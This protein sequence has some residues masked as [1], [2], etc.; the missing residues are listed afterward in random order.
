[1]MGEL[2]SKE[3]RP[4]LLERQSRGGDINEG[5]ISFQLEVV[6]SMIPR[7][8]SVEGF[9]GII[10]EGMADTEA[11][12]FV[13]ARGYKKEFIEVKDHPVTPIEFWNEIE[14]FQQMDA[15]S[16]GEYE[17][18]TVKSAGLSQDLHPLANGLR[19]LRDPYDFYEGS[20]IMDNSYSEYARIVTRLG[21]PKE[22]GDFLYRKVLIY[23]DL[24]TVRDHGFGV[25]QQS[26]QNYLPPYREMSGSVLHTVHGDVSSLVQSKRN[27]PI[28]RKEL[29]A[30]LRK[31]VP[32]PLL[33]PHQ[34]VRIHTAINR[35]ATDSDRTALRFE[36]ERFFAHESRKYPP[37]DV[38]N[39]ELLGELRATKDWILA[40]R[41]TRRIALSGNRRLSA[42][43]AIGSVFSAVAGFSIEMQYRE[44]IYATDTHAGPDTPAY[45]LITRAPEEPFV[46]DHL[47]VSIGILRDI[48]PE[49]DSY[50][51]SCGMADMPHLHLGGD[52][53]IESA[54]QANL[55]VRQIKDLISDTLVKTGSRQID[56]FIAAPAFLAL[57]LGH[58][59]N[60]TA[61]VRCYEWTN[62]SGYVPTC[63][64]F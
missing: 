32:E 16:P 2:E 56:L 54:E 55:I 14:R 57:F 40:N 29:E 48:V 45:P 23:K 20:V 60:A 42:T 39:E 36:W 53:A 22:V 18:F 64:L 61:Q 37:A 52:A 31:G 6:L 58:R 59:L 63:T 3:K 38:W 12:F 34:P 8:M 46:G 51:A 15:G 5:G 47:V 43:L 33:P 28:T 62:T 27:Q 44:H 13:P 25:F 35:R 4:S 11:K 7:L 1:M 19:R 30:A 26:L 9:E 49:V 21:K 17:W 41:G 10:R 24:S 50:L